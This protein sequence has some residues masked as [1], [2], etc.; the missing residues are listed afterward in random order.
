MIVKKKG[1]AQSL[2]EQEYVGKINM[3]TK[4]GNI[5]YP[6]VYMSEFGSYAWVTTGNNNQATLSRLTITN[7]FF[8]PTSLKT[9][10]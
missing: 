2:V 9:I 3:H 1:T 10:L 5:H 4:K 6:I 7:V 8:K